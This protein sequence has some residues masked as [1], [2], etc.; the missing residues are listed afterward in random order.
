MLL[1][2]HS[3]CRTPATRR[4]PYQPSPAAAETPA[5]NGTAGKTAAADQGTP[6]ST[7]KAAAAAGGDRSDRRQSG[8][9]GGGAAPE[10]APRLG[11]LESEGYSLQPSLQELQVRMLHWDFS[12]FCLVASN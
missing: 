11:E 8:A 2:L 5:T 4:T 3:I 9:G 6:A 10:D 1:L 12:M 7:S